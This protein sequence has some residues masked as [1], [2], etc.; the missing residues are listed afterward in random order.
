MDLK[1]DLEGLKSKLQSIENNFSDKITNVCEREELNNRLEKKL[2]DVWE[3]KQSSLV[4]LNI[5]GKIYTT[6]VNTLLSCTESIFSKTVKQYQS[7]GEKLPEELFYDRSYQH[8]EIILNYLR[9]GNLC[10][11]GINKYD[12]EE[13][14]EEIVFY[15]LSNLL[16]NKREEYDIIWD[17]TLSKAGAC[18]IDTNDRKNIRIHSTT[19][20]T[21]FVTDK[22]WT[23]EDFQIELEV[24][25]TQ[26]DN[27]LYVGL[28][29]SSYILTSNCGCCNP[30]NSFYLQCDGSLHINSAT[31]PSV[32][33]PWNSQKI[34]I[35]MKV[36][37]SESNK[38]IYFY[39]PER[40]D[41]EI[42]PYNLTGSNFRVYSGHCNQ[43]NG[44]IKI[45]DCFAIKD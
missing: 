42:G 11:K 33:Q 4:N 36:Y 13:I 38:R 41:L 37:L 22:V 32:I 29:N 6:R 15:G 1:K 30:Q 40:N 8:F 44:E 26:G 35:G 10:L 27:L 9:Y 43:G 18:T 12:K 31:T 7:N 23:N 16:I 5:G 28:Q 39:F 2:N 34:I 19:C 45:L 25:V 3:T 17:N 14:R 20:Y 21:H 24:A